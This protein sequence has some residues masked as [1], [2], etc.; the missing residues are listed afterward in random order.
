MKILFQHIFYRPEPIGNGTYTGEMC[1]WLAGKGHEISV[2]CP[3]PYYPHWSVPSPYRQWQ[4]RSEVVNGIQVR[5]C[6]IWLPRKTRGAQRVLHEL[7]FLLFSLPVM[8]REALRSPDLVF[9]L[10]PSL[11]NGVSALLA[12]RICGARCWLHVQDFEIDIAFNLPG[13]G[14][15]LLRRLAL[16]CERFLMRRFDVVSSISERMVERLQAKGV[17]PERTALFP[18]WVD[19]NWIYPLEAADTLRAEMGV[20]PG[21]LVAL[22]SGTLG[23]KQGVD[24]LI[25][26]ARRLE[27]R[28]DVDI[29]ICGDGGVLSALKRQ[30]EGLTN[31]RFHPLQPLDRLN[32]L[33]SSADIHVLTQRPQIADLVMP[34]KL[35]GMLA[36]GR[37]IVATAAAGTEVFKA[38]SACG[39]VTP[40]DDPG[41][42]AEAI[43]LLAKNPQHRARLGSAGR[44]FA[45]ARLEKDRVLSAFE[46]LLV[47]NGRFQNVSIWPQPHEE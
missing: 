26:A 11:V 22:F 37:P 9:V 18:N 36:S 29:V 44:Q 23:P 21:R 14:A 15:G 31:V 7:S 20:P 17:P 25:E 3:P 19:T 30:A 33:L 6:P 1:E 24:V 32:A 4:Y 27:S 46:R 45:I 35:L 13:S 40:P 10:E 2:V 43:T 12:A 39:I 28:V 16:C 47:T 34:S 41:A 8:L 38:V 42:L 5:R